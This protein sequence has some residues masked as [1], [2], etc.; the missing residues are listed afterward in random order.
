MIK[1]SK[2]NRKFFRSLIREENGT[3]VVEF[4]LIAIPLTIMMMGTMDAG[5]AYYVKAV[6]SG[7]LNKLARSSSLEGA[8]V[9]AQQTIIDDR[10]KATIKL[11]APNSTINIS[12]RYYKTFSKA[13]AATA[14]SWTDNDPDGPSGPLQPNGICDNGEPYVDANVN[15]NWDDDGGD[16]G[17]GG[18]KDVVIIK[19]NV[20]YKRLFPMQ[21]LTGLGDDVVL[22]SD[23]IL[24]NQPFGNQN[25]Y[26][27]AVTRNCS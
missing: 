3:S 25:G 10:M 27:T 22:F 1:G 23:S 9:T 16:G 18:A 24:A 26:T 13:A 5:H 8:S 15:S 7:E 19:V 11:I 20:S 4:G 17:Q 21:N 12:R 2:M 14:E 6:L